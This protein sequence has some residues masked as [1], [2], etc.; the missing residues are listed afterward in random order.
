MLWLRL[1]LFLLAVVVGTAIYAP[2]AQAQLSNL[3]T[4]CEDAITEFNTCVTN[5][6]GN[7]D[8]CDEHCTAASNG[9]ASAADLPK[10][11]PAHPDSAQGPGSVSK[12]PDYMFQIC[13][14]AENERIDRV[15][16]PVT[17]GVQESI[18][19]HVVNA[20]TFEI[21]T[22]L[23]GEPNAVELICDGENW[24][25]GNSYGSCGATGAEN[26]CGEEATPPTINVEYTENDT[27]ADVTCANGFCASGEDASHTLELTMPGMRDD[28]FGLKAGAEIFIEHQTCPFPT[29]LVRNPF[30]KELMIPTKCGDFS[31]FMNNMPDAILDTGCPPIDYTFCP[32]TPAPP[33]LSDANCLL[34]PAH[35][36]GPFSTEADVIAAGPCA[37]SQVSGE[38]ITL[39]GGNIMDL[40]TRW[41]WQCE[42][43][44]NGQIVTGWASKGCS[45]CIQCANDA[46]NTMGAVECRELD[47]G[48]SAF[49]GDVFADTLPSADNSACRLM[50]SCGALPDENG[51]CG[52]ATSFVG[53]YTASDVYDAGPCSG[54]QGLPGSDPLNIVD[55]GNNFEWTCL[56]IGG[57]GTDASCSVGQTIDGACGGPLNTCTAGT[58]SDVPDDAAGQRW[59][60]VGLNGGTTDNCL[61]PFD[62]TGAF[63]AMI[64]PINSA[65]GTTADEILIPTNG[66]YTYNYDVRVTDAGGNVQVLT[67]RT[68][69]T[70]ITVADNSG[71]AEIAITG[72]FPHWLPKG[73]GPAIQ[74]DDSGIREIVQWGNIEWQSMEGMFDGADW[75]DGFNG[76]GTPDLSNVTSMA[77][78]FFSADTFTNSTGGPANLSNWDVSNVTN[79]RG[80]FMSADNF[81]GDLSSWNVSNVQNFSQMFGAAYNFDNFNQDMSGWNTSNATNMARMF[82]SAHSFNADISLWDVSGVID[83]SGMFNN[84]FAFNQDISGW[85]VSNTWYFNQMFRN[86]NS[87]NQD[88]S[89]WDMSSARNLQGMFE[90]AGS[91]DQDLGSWNIT[92]ATNLQNMLDNNA[93]TDTNYSDTLIGWEASG[94]HPDNMTLGALGHLYTC[95]AETARS[96]L[97][98][99]HGWTINDAGLTGGPCGGC[100]T[101]ASQYVT[102]PATD[103]ASGCTGTSTYTDIADTGTDWQWTCNG[104]A[105]SA[106][107]DLP[108]CGTSGSYTTLAEGSAGNCSDG[109]VVGGSFTDNGVGSTFTWQCTKSGET[110]SCSANHIGE[111][112]TLGGESW[113]VGG[114]TCSATAPATNHN[115]NASITDSSGTET[116]S[117]TFRCIDGSFVE[118]PGSTC[119]T[120]SC[121]T[122]ADCATATI[123]TE[124]RYTDPIRVDLA[125]ADFELTNQTCSESYQPTVGGGVYM[126]RPEGNVPPGWSVS[127]TTIISAPNPAPTSMVM[128]RQ[129]GV[130]GGD[131]EGWG[132]QS[133]EKYQTASGEYCISGTCTP[134][135]IFTYSS[136]NTAP[137]GYTCG[138]YPA[139]NTTITNGYDD[140]DFCDPT[141]Q[142][143]PCEIACATGPKGTIFE[144]GRCE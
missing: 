49:S 72:T 113:T 99:D 13:R 84:A 106:N 141:E 3:P 143:Y 53:F 7:T 34:G 60:C 45:I 20:K 50:L 42:E 136:P 122:N 86:A 92:S 75:F 46:G 135:T 40:S 126:Y 101:F 59:D 62:A 55:M 54:G 131:K 130:S 82:Q 47:A 33:L 23:N 44:M 28:M 25:I 77:R 121:S 119:V 125:G 71:P 93:M 52:P 51:S 85:D 1:G 142:T 43:S 32:T 76:S 66:G 73:G 87:F 90:G 127:G 17:A 83:L 37:T 94:L 109:T 89:I 70:T 96:A 132:Y 104:T 16:E 31:N 133:C 38:T 108:A 103:T 129:T 57:G 144:A 98:N 19:S 12:V 2:S 138:D 5:Y 78:M 11:C 10:F 9:G 107:K 120:S 74:R 15:P 36:G 91:F 110:I 118:Q 67:G 102:Q 114:N 21:F 48:Y 88:L 65:D 128:A 27:G 79:M 41:E 22:T 81:N 6:P 137:P 63:I 80:M 69:D 115:N 4:D 68:G 112:C 124:W 105:C 56:G 140:G 29:H 111:S 116:G 24:R 30:N 100:V 18:T 8:M 123:T 26:V 117:A 14:R 97:I 35:Q 64:N 95:S 58:F 61:I 134:A 39:V 139:C